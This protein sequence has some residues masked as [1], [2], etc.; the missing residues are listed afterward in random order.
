MRKKIN[1]WLALLCNV[2]GTL[3]AVY[4]GGW[5][6]FLRPI[7]TLY[8]AFLGHEMTIQLVLTCG[9][10]ILLST[11]FAGLVWCIGYIGSNFFKGDED[12][13]WNVLNAKVDEQD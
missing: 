6:M 7:H 10:K 3:A 2:L 12:P 4:V 9:V 13:D 8:T 5:M 11:T 1:Q